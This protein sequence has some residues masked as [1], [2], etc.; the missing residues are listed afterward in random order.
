MFF[1]CLS[2]RKQRVQDSIWL[3]ET[4][5]KQDLSE[6]RL[7][8]L[9]EQKEFLQQRLSNIDNL[10]NGN[11]R[12]SIQKFNQAVK[13]LAKKL[14]QENRLKN[15]RLGAGPKP[16]LDSDDEEFIARAIESKSTAHGRRYDSVLYTGHRVKHTCCP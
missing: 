13:R 3:L 7:R 14:A 15:R 6:K 16:L 10:I 2:E 8:E 11:S 12:V 9:T 5:E 1:L 4:K